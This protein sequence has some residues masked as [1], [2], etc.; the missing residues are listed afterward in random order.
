MSNH[1]PWW[2]KWDPADP[3]GYWGTALSQMQH[4]TAPKLLATNSNST[5]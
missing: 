1:F 2:D 5:D 3:D 4:A